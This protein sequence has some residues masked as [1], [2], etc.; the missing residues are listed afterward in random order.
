ILPLVGP[1]KLIMGMS[2]DS[3]QWHE[4][5]LENESHNICIVIAIWAPIILVYF[6][7]TQIWYAIYATVF[8]GIVGVFS[9]LGEIR[10][11]GML[12][13]RFQSVPLAFFQC[14]WT[15]RDRKNKQEEEESVLHFM[16]Q[17]LVVVY[18]EII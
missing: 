3:F 12:G 7:D 2:I 18:N 4:F 9:H 5:F 10:T 1:T 8:G 14:F 17:I 15:G 13:S 11:L 6:M 16:F